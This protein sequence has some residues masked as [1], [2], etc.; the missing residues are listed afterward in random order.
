LEITAHFPQE[1]FLAGA[2]AARAETGTEKIT[3]AAPHSDR[4]K[5]EPARE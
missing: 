1:G 4:S 5:Q 2:G 3:G